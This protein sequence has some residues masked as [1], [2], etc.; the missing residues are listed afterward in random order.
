MGRCAKEATGALGGAWGTPAT[1][2]QCAGSSTAPAGM[3]GDSL[4]PDRG[5]PWGLSTTLHQ[6]LWPS[7][8]CLPHLPRACLLPSS[9]G[10]RRAAGE[11]ISNGLKVPGGQRQIAARAR[12]RRPRLRRGRGVR[13]GVLSLADAAPAGACL[14]PESPAISGGQRR[15][16]QTRAAP[17]V[18]AY[19]G[20]QRPPRT[21]GFP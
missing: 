3:R 4:R 19:S 6:R 13:R 17:P 20:P 2:C 18:S 15:R 11:G 8:R 12:G 16:P 5:S 1:S 10:Y 9:Q 7:S 21:P 14:S